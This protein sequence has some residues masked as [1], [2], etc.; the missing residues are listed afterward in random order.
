MRSVL[1]LLSC[2][3]LMGAGRY[4]RNVETFSPYRRVTMEN[5]F[6]I[7]TFA[8]DQLGRLASVRLKEK[9]TE[10]TGEF[11]LSRY[12]ETPL[13]YLDS[14]N[15]HGIREL[16][17]R[18]SLSGISPMKEEIRG[19]GKISFTSSGYGGSNVGLNRTVTLHPE[20]LWAVF[21]SVLVNNGKSDEKIAVWL[22]LQGAPP[23]VPVI[24]VAGKGSVP[25]RG[26]M[27][28]YHR[29]FLFNGAGGNSNLP[30]AAEWAGFTLPGR[31]VVWVVIAH[32]LSRGG[33]YY[34]WGN[35]DHRAPIRT[36]EPIFP[37][38]VVK[39]G[40]QSAP[41]RYTL[42]VFPGLE[43]INALCGAKG[44][45]VVP[46]GGKAL[47]RICSALP[48]K[49]AEKLTLSLF[50]DKG[51]NILQMTGELPPGKAGTVVTFEEK[52]AGKAVSGRIQLG[53]MSAQIFFT[54]DK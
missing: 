26:V 42:A 16:F 23:A 34:S 31:K 51:K 8:P 7:L 41:L 30:G 32:G 37:E 21:E 35:Q 40:E 22:N 49:Q 12:T 50:D 46:Q 5:P 3:L 10:L 36:V 27:N 19:K 28:L 54:K 53:E 18:R 24:P 13:F 14:D 39:P 17:W 29:P 25:Q 1:L 33:Y 52:C 48:V 15:F 38:T 45:E 6:L 20:G 9:G 43:N 47:I 44:I 4:E 11:K 2:A